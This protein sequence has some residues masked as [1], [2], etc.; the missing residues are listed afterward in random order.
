MQFMILFI[1]QRGVVSGPPLPGVKSSVHGAY[2]IGFIDIGA[3]Y[4]TTPVMFNKT[5]ANTILARVF[6]IALP[7]GGNMG[8]YNQ[9]S[10]AVLEALGTSRQGLTPDEAV[11]RLEKY[12]HNE[13]H[14]AEKTPLWKLVLEAWKDPMMIILAIVVI[15]KAV[16]GEFVE[17]AVIMAVLVVNSLISVIQTRKAES[18]LEALRQISAPIAKVRRGGEMASIPA[19]ELVPGD[20]VLL[21][22]GDLVPADGRIIQCHALKV[23]EGLLTGESEPVL[24]Q[25][26]A[27]EGVCAGAETPAAEENH[28]VVAEENHLV[29]AEENHLVVAEENH[30]VVAEEN[31]LVVAEENHL[32]VAE[33]NHLV[34]ADRK[35]MV[36][37]GTIAVHG[38]GEFLV[39]GTGKQ[40]EI[41]K[42]ATLIETAQ[43]RQTPLQRRLE[44]FS[45]KLGL[46]IMALCALIFAVQIARAITDGGELRD[47]I[48]SAFLFA[49]AVAVAA[50]PEALS[51]IVTIVLAV[52]TKKM[53][54]QNA[55]IRKLPAVEALGS[56][57][58]ICTD[59]TGTLTQNKMTVIDYFLPGGIGAE[60]S[61]YSKSKSTPDSDSKIPEICKSLLLP[62]M[63]LC[64]DAIIKAD[65]V[66]IGDPTETALL[67]FADKNG[68]PHNEVREAYSRLAELPFDSERKLMSVAVKQLA[69]D[70]ACK[71]D[72]IQIFTKGAPD[73]LFSRCT[74]VL[75]NGEAVPITAGL[76]AQFEAANDQFSHKALRVLAYATKIINQKSGFDI[77]E[78]TGNI[79]PNKENHLPINEKNRLT[80]IEENHL[81]LIGLTAMIDPPRP[82]VYE[83]IAAAKA[84]HIKTVMITGDHKNTAYAIASE[85]GI[86]TEG[87]IAVTGAELDAMTP[88]ELEEK[89]PSISVYARVSPENK[90]SIVR[91]WQQKGMITAMTGD[92][93]N[94]APS[95][96]QADIGV[97][98]G[99]G[100]EV[101][102]DASAMILTDDNFASIVSAV[103]TG[104]TIFDNIK[105]AVGYLFSGN[106]AAIIAILFAFVMGW[107][108][109]LTALQILFINLV[110][111]SIPAIALGLEKGEKAVMSR[112][113]RD[114]NEGIFG[115]GLFTSVIKRGILIGAVAIASQFIGITWFSPAVG[116]AM[117]FTTI[118]L[119]RT[120]QT[121]S[122]RSNS[123]TIFGLGFA[124]NPYVLWAVVICL[125]I[126][127][128]TI[129]PGLRTV[130]HIPE[131]FTAL[132]FGLAS[133]LA[134]LAVLAMEVVKWISNRQ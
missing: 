104:R 130:F 1:Y 2:P 48:L 22:A 15:I 13:L 33:E 52:G 54:A 42:I 100:T 66:T 28:L 80:S 37:S 12:G 61:I 132:H 19:K 119:A 31:H 63:V 131:V 84:A 106:L 39:T 76:L 108:S 34:L 75:I 93:V 94:D 122:S 74:H 129:L 59:K 118:I 111:D 27:L 32:V 125:G 47:V 97:A 60:D 109:P 70:G 38:R 86:V 45:K 43:D 114:M 101:S 73:V 30:L 87:D 134:G 116:G 8:I 95:L 127:G 53:A 77:N 51:S 78:K 110:N 50:I 91:A 126:Y 133:G 16:L 102:K 113:P 40:A 68:K 6:F 89:L 5:F 35:N 120:L 107:D 36:Y 23:D 7:E 67:A 115:G 46:A 25:E 88:E 17:A 24:K 55:I 72:D 14:Q 56:T 92:G 64:N 117:A 41:G 82:E 20:I 105:K 90:I 65:G 85:I 79:T 98:M 96:K 9:S 3:K 62:A 29:V 121:F 103:A 4:F 49:L 124:S 123:Q 11:S 44:D 18:S 69:P 128:L 57:G 71:A 83:S 58:V 81:I 26:G 112:P 21:E 10:E 99:S